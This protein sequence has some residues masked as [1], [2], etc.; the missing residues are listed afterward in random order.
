[1][2]LK[3]FLVKVVP[4]AAMVAVEF[5][6]VGLTTISK[7]AM[8]RGASH[9]I[10]VVYANAVGSLILLPTSFFI[11]RTKRPPLTFAFLCKVFLLSLVGIT[12]M[13][14]CVFTG[15]S[16]SSPTLASAMSN[17]IP[18]LTFLLAVIFR[19]EK[20][21]VKSLRS[22]IKITGALLSI[23][24]AII[25]ILYKGP[26]IAS[27]LSQH[28]QLQSSFSTLK[29]TNNW[30]IGGFLLAIASLSFAILNISQA[31][32]LKGYPSEITLV[33]FYSCFGSIQCAIV[34]LIAERNPNAWK[35]KPDIELICVMY[36]A[37]F[38]N[39]MTFGVVAWCI[40]RKG[41]VFVAMF[42]PVG[43]SIA[44]FLSAIFL[45]DT[46]HVGSVI[47]SIIIIAGFYG[48]MWAQSKEEGKDRVNQDD[49]PQQLPSNRTPLL[50]SERHVYV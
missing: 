27:L 23:S 19:M 33:A 21:D 26:S 9:F 31:A 37:V 42:K 46:L 39:V 50:E 47:G 40:H 43:I 29:T 32:I 14:N 16:Y 1:M 2:G 41:P 6:D 4:F 5:A 24:G 13:Q 48:V 35:I 11:N 22:Q 28:Q 8:S 20:L 3:S 36:S 7:A 10:L 44:A 49:N 45:G 12:L 15:V 25:T 18:A 38:G 34:A 30:V 17:L